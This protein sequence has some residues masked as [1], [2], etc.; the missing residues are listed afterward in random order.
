MSKNIQ[1]KY[2]KNKVKRQEKKK[3][4]EERNVELKTYQEH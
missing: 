4:K 3:I 2:N 1:I